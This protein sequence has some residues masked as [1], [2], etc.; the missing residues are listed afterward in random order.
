MSI[1][2]APKVVL[3]H[4]ENIISGL[5]ESFFFEDYDIGQEYARKTFTS[6]LL[7]IYVKDP[8]MDIDDTFWWSEDE[9]EGI[10]QK[11][12]TGSIMYQLKSDGILNSYEDEN[13]E[14]TFFLTEKGKLLSQKLKN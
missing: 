1:H 5:E 13:T 11:I 4:L 8:S 7:E 12:V 9:F 3:L 2:D 6:L 14:E 10:L